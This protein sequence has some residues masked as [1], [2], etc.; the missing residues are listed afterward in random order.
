[1]SASLQSL[2]MSQIGDAPRGA[3]VRD[4]LAFVLIGT[5]A[6]LSFVALSMLAVALL[7]MVPAW[8]V[9]ALCYAGFVLPVYLLHRRFSFRSNAA[10]I[11][12]LPRY[13]IVQFGGI[14]LATLFSWLAYGFVGLPTMVA[15]LTVIGVTSALNFAVL[16]LWAFRS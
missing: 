16:R 12:A 11:R 13:V 7:P 10:H 14:A 3:L 5:G 9:S 15:A 4:L 1:M 2:M 8:L 6:A